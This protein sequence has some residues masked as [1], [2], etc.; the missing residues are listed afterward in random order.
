MR[1][2]VTCGNLHACTIGHLCLDTDAVHS[3]LISMRVRK[4]CDE[5]SR[6]RKKVTECRPRGPG[7]K[8]WSCAKWV[9]ECSFIDAYPEALLGLNFELSREERQNQR[10]AELRALAVAKGFVNDNCSD[11]AAAAAPAPTITH[12]AQRAELQPAGRRTSEQGSPSAA[13]APSPQ[14]RQDART[15]LSCSS[16]RSLVQSQTVGESI[17]Q[18]GDGRPQAK[19]HRANGTSPQYVLA[20]AAA[21]AAAS[22]LE[23]T[24]SDQFLAESEAAAATLAP[25]DAAHMAL[26]AW[27]AASSPSSR[28]ENTQ[29]LTKASEG[30]LELLANTAQNE[31]V[32][33]DTN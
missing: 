13:A 15:D 26:V 29:P 23:G 22:A 24:S 18:A 8:C 12:S 14:Q 4:C 21:N 7:R 2:G 32:K 9:R 25:K 19:K 33:C 6:R 10:T 28:V 3:D 17:K 11:L 1:I 20:A 31:G 27:A 5:C 16:S 30:R